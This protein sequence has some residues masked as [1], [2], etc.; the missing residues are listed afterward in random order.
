MLKLLS[1]L[2]FLSALLFNEMQSSNQC[3]LVILRGIQLGMLGNSPRPSLHLFN[4]FPFVTLSVNTLRESSER[5]LVRCPRV[6]VTED[7]NVTELQ[8]QHK[9]AHHSRFYSSPLHKGSHQAYHSHIF[10]FIVFLLTDAKSIKYRALLKQN[11][12]Q[13]MLYRHICEASI[14]WP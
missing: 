14:S 13:N 5:T 8:L 6:S 3:S 11:I 7:L 12:W 10:I 1:R 9:Q 2:S 4:P